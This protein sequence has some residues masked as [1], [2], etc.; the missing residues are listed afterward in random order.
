VTG[1]GFAPHETVKLMFVQGKKKS[2]LGSAKANASGAIDKVVTIP[3]TAKQGP[4][5]V[6]ASG[7]TS[8][9]SAKAGF[10]VS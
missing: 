1:S 3:A 6:K 4:A 7:A 5:S 9:L 8:A 2:K 10:T